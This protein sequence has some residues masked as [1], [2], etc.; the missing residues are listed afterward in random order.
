MNSP[1]DTSV[2]KNMNLKRAFSAVE[3]MVVIGII[4]IIAAVAIPAYINIK[5]NQKEKQAANEIKLIDEAIQRFRDDLGDYPSQN[6][7]E[8]NSSGLT[9]SE[10]SLNQGNEILVA[11]LYSVLPEKLSKSAY[12]QIG[13]TGEGGANLE[14]SDSDGMKEL[15]D[16]WGKPYHYFPNTDYDTSVSH[17]YGTPGLNTIT[18]SAKAKTSGSYYRLTSYQIWSM[19]KNTKN[20]TNTSAAGSQDDDDIVNWSY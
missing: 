8:S 20:D 12:L 13:L 19:G 2:I 6:I 11:C 14:D 4:V 9:D 17:S 15:V 7:L 1:S 5:N 16:P 10:K 18:A 3:L